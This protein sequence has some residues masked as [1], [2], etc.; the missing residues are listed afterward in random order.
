MLEYNTIFVY[1]ILTPVLVLIF[2]WLFI[3]FEIFEEEK[4]E[5]KPKT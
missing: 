5:K 3:Y 2:F 1:G 4:K